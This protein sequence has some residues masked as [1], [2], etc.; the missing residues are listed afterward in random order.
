MSKFGDD[1]DRFF[2]PDSGFVSRD[3]LIRGR[4]GKYVRL[5]SLTR[6]EENDAIDEQVRR[7][8]DSMFAQGNPRGSAALGTYRSKRRAEDIRREQE[9]LTACLVC[10]ASLTGKYSNARTCSERCK[11]ALQRRRPRAGKADLIR[12]G[13]APHME[14]S[15]T[16]LSP[17]EKALLERT[18]EVFRVPM[19]PGY[20]GDER[21]WR[22]GQY[23]TLKGAV[24]DERVL[25]DLSVS[26]FNKRARVYIN[27]MKQL[28]KES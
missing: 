6:E 17:L 14:V 21:E 20:P 3:G 28:A 1:L 15:V 18:L 13:F 22:N 9:R 12:P 16:R 23:L 11:K 26:R 19:P 4:D 25:G 2:G 10:G 7:V 24:R 27:R 8:I 5:D